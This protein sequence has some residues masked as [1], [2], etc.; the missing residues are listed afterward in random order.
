[1]HGFHECVM[2]AWTKP[3][4]VN[5]KPMFTLHT[6]L[7]RTAKSLRSWAKQLIL[8]GKV[9][10]AICREVISQLEVAQENRQ[11]SLAEIQLIRQLKA[12]IL[13]LAAIEKSRAK[14]KSRVTWLKKGDANTKYFQIVANNRKRKN[15]I[16][17]LLTE[18]G[19]ATTQRRKHEVVFK[20]YQSHI[21]TATPW[22][23][24][25]NLDTLGWQPRNLEN[26][27]V[28]FTEEEVK[29]VIMQGPKDKAPGLDGSI[30]L[31]Y[32]KWWEII[33]EDIMGAINQFYNMNQ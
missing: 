4:P 26:L 22:T 6:K 25:L 16:H 12:R 8:Q 10:I 9:T 1:M 23:Y 2:Q 33:K 5:Q 7:N 32:K 21:G 31:F 29:V 13:G 28:P 3:V 15:F 11:L 20:H 30:G 19:T 17:C 24:T 18:N 14:Q 27:D